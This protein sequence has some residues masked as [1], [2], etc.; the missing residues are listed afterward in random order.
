MTAE[1]LLRKLAGDTRDLREIRER[2]QTYIDGLPKVSD[3]ELEAQATLEAELLGLLECL[4][5]DDL[6]PALAKLESLAAL[7]EGNRR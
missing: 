3:E 4:V 6:D 2:V 5:A 1:E 7:E